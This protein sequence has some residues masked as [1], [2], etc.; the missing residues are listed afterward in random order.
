M[1]IFKPK[2]KKVLQGSKKD[3]IRR[4][5]KEYYSKPIPFFIFIRLTP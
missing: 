4:A 2:P 3:K 1:K 5:Y